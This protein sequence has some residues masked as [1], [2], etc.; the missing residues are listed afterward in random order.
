MPTFTPIPH[1]AFEAQVKVLAADIIDSGWTPSFIIGIGRGG[2]APAVYLSHRLG[3][4]LVS[5]DHSTR[6]AQ[7]GEELVAVLAGRT[8]AGEHLVMREGREARCHRFAA[9][10][11]SR[12]ARCIATA[13]S[14]RKDPR[15]LLR[16]S[17]T[18]ASRPSPRPR[19]TA[20]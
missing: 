17:V 10:H 14:G 15:K 2:L 16:A 6:I 8:R 20:R 7:F 18:S 13:S 19:A 5:I 4:P 9:C 11:A 1:D 3:L 12:R